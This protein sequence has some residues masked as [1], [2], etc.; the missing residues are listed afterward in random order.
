[1]LQSI[2]L[3][4]QLHLSNFVEINTDGIKIVGKIGEE[5]SG[6][7]SNFTSNSLS[8]SYKDDPQLTIKTEGIQTPQATVTNGLTVT[9]GP[10]TLGSLVIQKETNGSY[11][12]II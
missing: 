10:I 8:F 6:Y 4:W 12:F 11:S 7:S 5:Y 1:M 9:N 2:K 3:L